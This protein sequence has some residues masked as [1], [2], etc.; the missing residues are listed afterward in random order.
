[1]TF[2]FEAAETLVLDITADLA[3]G[4]LSTSGLQRMIL[5]PTV[6]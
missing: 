4:E 3:M 1:M 5:S 6:K 2:S